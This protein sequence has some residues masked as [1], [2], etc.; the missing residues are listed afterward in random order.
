MASRRNNLGPQDEQ[1]DQAGYVL[2]RFARLKD[3]Q[4]LFAVEWQEI[5]DY[6][7]PRKNSI[8]VQR[9]P[10]SKR[11]QRLYD[12]TAL[13]A[14]DKLASSIHGTLTPEGMR[15]F[16]LETDDPKLQ[17]HQPTR[18]WLEACSER[19]NS[20]FNKSNF[21]QESHEYYVDIAA[22]GTAAMF[23][24][25]KEDDAKGNWQGF[26]FKTLGP[27]KYA[28][29]EGPDGK[30]NALFRS[31]PMSAEA[32]IAQ[33]PDSVPE[34]VRECAPDKRFEIIHGVYPDEPG[35]EHKYKSL[36]FVYTGRAILGEPGAGAKPKRD[37]ASTLKEGFFEEFPFCVARWSKNPDETYGRGP[38]HNAM[39][40][41]RSLNKIVELE[42]R[43]L[44]I[45]VHPPLKIL[46]GD[47]IGP[48]RM[49]PGGQTT[50]RSMDGIQPL[51]T[52]AENTYQIVNLK[53]EE[54]VK[55]IQRMYYYDQL[56][57]PQGPQ[58][59][60]EEIVTRMELMNRLMGP[61]SGRLASEFLKPMIDRCWAIM[62][63][64]AISEGLLTG[65]DT[66]VLPAIP[67]TTLQMWQQMKSPLP[68][69][70][71]FEGPL[72]R[73]QRSA[74][75]G[76]LQKFQAFL[77]PMIQAKPEIMD[78]VNWDKAAERAA[79]VVGV[80]A[81]VMASDEEIQ[82][83]RQDRQQQQQQAAQEQTMMN[84]AQAAGQAAPMA[85]VMQGKSE[86]G[87]PD[88]QLAGA[89]GGANGGNQA[90]T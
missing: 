87:S 19:M 56:Q 66:S 33:W 37:Q 74:D 21:S 30:A 61:A 28:I 46:N 53:K 29:G 16:F 50:V 52:G 65:N 32:I 38:S 67:A 47:A 89:L 69:R 31:W 60:A 58:M 82:Q 45:D 2:Q 25:E 10:G 22:F 34:D 27:A 36:Y 68:L 76:A 80:P 18:Q 35:A 78:V 84:T 14:L 13:D 49:V 42:L 43:R 1:G 79:E 63:R 40:D 20:Q 54:L 5:S 6:I 71:R 11:T 77:M 72:A 86:D 73:A 15:W 8:V 88:Q 7:I 41:V 9:V 75:M 57:L 4:R 23:V 24:E 17:E 12:S 59:T 3:A 64:R 62:L 85:K 70:I 44:A 81:D 39:P 51:L 55:S 48:I 26:Q 83:T 90:Q